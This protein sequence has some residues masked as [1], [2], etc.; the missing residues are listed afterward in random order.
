MYSPSL[1]PTEFRLLLPEVI[2]LETDHFA[3]ATTLSQNFSGEAL[4]WQNYVNALAL[5]G[6]R[7]WLSEKIPEQFSNLDHTSNAQLAANFNAGVCQLQIGEFKLCLIATEHVLDEVVQIPRAAIFDPTWA[8]H[9]YVVQ[10]VCLEEAQIMIRGFVRHDQLTHYLNQVDQLPLLDGCHPIPLSCF[11]PEPHHLLSYCQHLE[12]I[13]IPLPAISTSTTEGRKSSQDSKSKT[14]T[15]LSQWLQDRVEE[16]W[17]AI[18]TLIRP[19]TYLALNTRNSEPD[20]RKGKLLNLG[21]KLGQQSVVLLVIINPEPDEKLNVLVQL[22]PIC[23]QKY[24][25]PDIKLK[26]LSKSG[27]T[28]QEVQ[29][30]GQDNYI[31]LQPFKG[32]LGKCFSLEV[33]LSEISATEDFEL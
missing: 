13:A 12:A 27:K 2:W 14:K 33:N 29:A 15:H 3:Q 8:A 21:V 26:V 31:Q 9:F 32:S 16:G 20:I 1:A 19:A 18:D 24:L 23:G 30:R 7:Q 4:Q 11:D 22:H 10:E 5:L 17:L 28:L 6:F 25:P